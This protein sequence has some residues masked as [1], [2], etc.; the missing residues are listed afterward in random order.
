MRGSV[1]C[2][3]VLPRRKSPWTIVVSSLGGT[4]AGSHSISDSMA[5][6]RSVSEARYCWVHRWSCRAK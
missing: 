3:I 5:S 6:M 2:T 4:V 1:G